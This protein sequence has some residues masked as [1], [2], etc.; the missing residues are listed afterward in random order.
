MIK[1]ISLFVLLL[2]LAS[3][4]EENMGDKALLTDNF[5]RSEML[6]F[7]ADEII[8]PAYTAYVI[9]LDELQST[10]NVFIT[11][12]NENN[13]NT[14]RAAWLESYLAWQQ[15]SQFEIGKAEEIGVRNYSN[16]YPTNVVLIHSNIENQDY[17]LELPSNFSAQGFPALDYLLFGIQD[18]DEAIINTLTIDSTKSYLVAIIDRLVTLGNSV[19]DDWNN[20]FRNDF[21]SNDGSSATASTDKMVN[22]FLFFYERF[23]RAAKVGLPAGVFTGSE[24][25]ELV[26]GRYS[27]IYSKQLFSKAFE[28]SQN[29][30]KGISFDQQTEGPSLKQYLD[31]IHLD[32]NT[33]LD[34]STSIITQ[35]ASVD[36]ALA[37]SMESF[38]EQI[39]EDNT[40][41]L[42][43]YD[44]LQKAVITL[45]V[46]MLQALNIQVDFVDADGD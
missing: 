39:I 30:F 5:D 37:A 23:V 14:L 4:C 42:A 35:W 17:N 36:L 24:N 25:I 45:K 44:E 8:I 21:I 10:A 29:F 9:S 34:Y 18:T 13:L 31:E 28:A 43:I 16:I 11:A 6:R 32:N 41:M 15:V 26:E 3:S 12:P 20:S 27:S 22:D 2:M 7:W 33:T 1:N 46:D 19:S 40:K 38:K